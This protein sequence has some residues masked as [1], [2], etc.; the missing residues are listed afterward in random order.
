MEE[1]GRESEEKGIKDLEP[2]KGDPPG[3]PGG[4]VLLV[5]GRQV[6]PFLVLPELYLL[7]IIT[8]FKRFTFKREQLQHPL[9]PVSPVA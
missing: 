9:L 7:G 2:R 5:N 6:V 4:K 8:T 3:D 1:R